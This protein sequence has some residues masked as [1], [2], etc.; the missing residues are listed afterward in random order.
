[1]EKMTLSGQHFD[2]V[3]AMASALIA[4]GAVRTPGEAIGKAI[5]GYTG[6]M[7]GLDGGMEF[8]GVAI[9]GTITRTVNDS[10]AEIFE[11]NY[12]ESPSD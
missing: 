7:A 3:W 9:S 4:T 12:E 2:R 5:E 10:G 8:T 11:V 6:V 1:M